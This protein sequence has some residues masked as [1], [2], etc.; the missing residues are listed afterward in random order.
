MFY[1]H[2]VSNKSSFIIHNGV[3]DNN[4]LRLNISIKENNKFL[5]YYKTCLAVTI[6]N[7]PIYLLRTRVIN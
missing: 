3:I 6:D 2:Y 1:V 7:K 5:L 4:S